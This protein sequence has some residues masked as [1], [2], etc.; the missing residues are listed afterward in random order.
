MNFDLPPKIWLPPKPAIIR[1]AD[2]TLLRPQAASFL[3]GAFPAGAVAAGLGGGVPPTADVSQ[4]LAVDKTEGAAVDTNTFSWSGLACGTAGSNRLVLATIHW[5]NFQA[6]SNISL[7]SATIGGNSATIQVQT[8]EADEAT[9]VAIISYPLAS[10]TTT[11]IAITLSAN[12]VV[13]GV[14]VYAAYDL[15]S[16]TATHTDADE[17][18][19]SYSTGD[20]ETQTSSNIQADGILMI[21]GTG[22]FC[23]TTITPTGITLDRAT[24]DLG[25]YD[26][27]KMDLIANARRAS[28]IQDSFAA[29]TG[30]IVNIDWGSTVSSVQ[31]AA[32]FR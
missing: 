25:Q 5:S 8:N 6:N 9:G 3:P 7:S 22:C 13:A 18:L 31:V 26:P 1:P 20:D 32:A 15:S 16:N 12:V 24:A 2:K 30:K 29:T 11:T 23:F 14:E 4:P 17:D 28:A 21:A 10:G 19:G 27:D